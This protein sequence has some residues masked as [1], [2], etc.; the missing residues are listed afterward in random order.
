MLKF[1]ICKVKVIIISTSQDNLGKKWNNACKVLSTVP[2]TQQRSRLGNWYLF[3]F[4]S[5]IQISIHRVGK[6]LKMLSGPA[7]VP[8][9]IPHVSS[10]SWE[11]KD[12]PSSEWGIP[13]PGSPPPSVA[14]ASPS[15]LNGLWPQLLGLLPAPSRPPASGLCVFPHL[16]PSTCSFPLFAYL[17]PFFLGG[18]GSTSPLSWSPSLFPAT[19]SIPRKH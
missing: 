15:S 14:S 8:G 19:H 3:H 11:E 10:K 2:G 13:L 12:L 5:N 17:V 6:D 4:F 9:S 16:M 7:P 18:L 1:P